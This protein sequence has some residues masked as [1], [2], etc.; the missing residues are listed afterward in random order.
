MAINTIGL[1]S[2]GDRG[3]M[4]AKVLRSHGIRILTC[5]QGCSERTRMLAREAQIDAVP[6]D[7]DLVR[8]TE[9]VLSIV[10]PEHALSTARLVAGAM[11]TAGRNSVYVDCHAIAPGTMSAV[12]EAITAVGSRDHRTAPRQP[13]SLAF[14]PPGQR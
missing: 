5:L 8:E 3:S 7:E 6:T 10:V 2:P 11:R 9:M 4:V 13:V 12:S 1:L 14:T